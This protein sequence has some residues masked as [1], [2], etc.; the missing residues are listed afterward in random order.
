MPRQPE[1]FT[2]ALDPDE[3]QLLVTIT[4]TARDRVR[5]R[6]AG[7]VLASVQ[8]CSAAE[9]AAMYAA[10]PQYAREVIHA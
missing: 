1:V 9:A 6:R 10:K 8:G 3:A 7:I 5:L 2:R 4:R